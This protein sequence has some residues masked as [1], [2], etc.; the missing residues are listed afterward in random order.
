MKI[1][2]YPSQAELKALFDYNLETGILT[3]KVRR[4][5]KVNIGDIAGW[6]YG[7][8]YLAVTL[9]NKHYRVHRIVWIMSYGDIPDG[10]QIDHINHNKLDNRLENLRLATNS[11]NQCN[12]PIIKTNKSGVKGLSDVIN[13]WACEVE[14]R[15]NNTRFRKKKSFPFTESTKETQKEVAIAWLEHTRAELHGEFTNHGTIN[16]PPTPSI[17][18]L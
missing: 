11:E 15:R 13:A 17:Q 14:V 18:M 3:Y 2:Q 7:K 12:K 8:G 16:T 10:Y 9:S 4:S 1:N 5:N 6:K